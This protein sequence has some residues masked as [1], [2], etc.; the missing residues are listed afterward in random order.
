MRLIYIILFLLIY[1]FSHAQ[2][3]NCEPDSRIY[4]EYDNEAFI[5]RAIKGKIESE[6]ATYTKENAQSIEYKATK[7]NE[8]KDNNIL[9]KNT[10]MQ[11]IRLSY[12]EILGL[13][14]VK[15]LQEQIIELGKSR[16]KSLNVF[17]DNFSKLKR[18]GIFIVIL[19][20]IDPFGDVNVLMNESIEALKDRAI[21]DIIGVHIKS[22]TTVIDN[23]IIKDVITSYKAGEIKPQPEL[24]KY[25]SFDKKVFLYVGK[26]EAYPLKNA[27]LYTKD[28]I[29]EHRN[30][31]N[32]VINALEEDY[33]QKLLEYGF[34]QSIITE[35]NQKIKGQLGV[36]KNE[37][38]AA[39]QQERNFIEKGEDEITKIEREI[40]DINKKI[41]SRSDKIRNIIK[42]YPD[43]RITFDDKNIEACAEKILSYLQTLLIQMQKEWIDISEKELLIR[44]TEKFSIEGSVSDAL[45]K[46]SAELIKQLEENY[47][48]VMKSAELIE[49]ENLAVKDIPKGYE[50]TELYRKVHKVWIYPV[51]QSGGFS[52]LVIAKCRIYKREGNYSP[53]KPIVPPKPVTPPPK[54]HDQPIYKFASG[55]YTGYGLSIS[56]GAVAPW[57]TQLGYLGYT[58]WGGYGK[59]RLSN[60]KTSIVPN[61]NI[62]RHTFVSYSFGI[63]KRVFHPLYIYTGT[64][65]G[66]SFDGDVNISNRANTFKG[67]HL[68]MDIGMGI[69]CL[70]SSKLPF[71]LTLDSSL[72]MGKNIGLG[73]SFIFKD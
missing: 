34:D 23:R 19:P 51:P 48:K 5:E 1:T 22:V 17:N 40:E 33:A 60:T 29:S 39:D 12:Q 28:D 6:R 38:I 13:K 52:L 14:D 21:E 2:M 62:K 73:L 68:I 63:S 11:N 47:T 72:F 56:N 70:S 69:L 20:E 65:W 50:V 54:P 53:P 64:G 36:V 7:C 25:A 55:F 41:G 9:Q 15:K 57:G 30:K 18:T 24:Y 8:D 61:T 58:G 71:F 37:N 31:G 16:E 49:I 44:S 3:I 4:I 32:V 66:F 46:K 45:A 26:V 27:P 67:N 35:V 42:S 59:I 43:S 10:E